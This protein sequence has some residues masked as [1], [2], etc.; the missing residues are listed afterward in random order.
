MGN[1]EMGR[2]MHS[3]GHETGLVEAPVSNAGTT[4]PEASAAA[5]GFALDLRRPF[6]REYAGC[7][8]DNRGG[9]DGRDLHGWNLR[10][11]RILD[12][13]SSTGWHPRK[14][15]STDEN[16]LP[17]RLSGVAGGNACPTRTLIGRGS[18]IM[19]SMEIGAGEAIRR[20]DVAALQLYLA[21]NPE[22]V[23]ARIDGQRTLLHVATDWPGHFPNVRQT[24]TVLGDA[25]A[26]LNAPF[27]GRHA[28]TPL[29][30]AASS[31]DVEALDALLD[32]GAEIECQG[33]VIGGGAPLSDAVAFGCW[34]AARR[35]VERG[36]RSTIW[37][38]A[39]LGL[40]DRLREHF[41]NGAR[42]A[43]REVTNAFWNACSGGQLEAARYLLS[44]GADRNWV[45]HDQ[46]TPLG[47]AVRNQQQ[48]IIAWLSAEGGVLHP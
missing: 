19:G 30:W 6:G 24:I 3:L 28:E 37:Q 45:G 27:I 5:A 46:L 23:R 26:D 48:S 11:K 25:G 10:R 13:I 40:M 43:E 1:R 32:L 18:S 31:D 29:H 15:L 21:Q 8:L 16:L 36:A 47:V 4:S 9:S 20:G 42:P 2:E 7:N 44:Q 17:R 38:S 14:S 12:G 34:N 33:S 35:L 22:A 39:A 41:A